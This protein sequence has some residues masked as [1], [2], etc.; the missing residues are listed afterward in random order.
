VKRARKG[1]RKIKPRARF[2]K[3]VL[4]RAFETKRNSPAKFERMSAKLRD[5]VSEYEQIFDLMRS[6]SLADQINPVS[7][8]L[9]ELSLSA[10]SLAELR[11][12]SLPTIVEFLSHVPKH[13]IKAKTLEGIRHFVEFDAQGIGR[14]QAARKIY[15]G[16]KDPYR[17]LKRLVADHPHEIESEKQRLKSK[18]PS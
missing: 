7:H 14:K 4:L 18:R 10:E 15:P 5:V 8:K 1:K 9:R 11:G 3:A 13:P 2:N 6:G 17:M 16:V 12:V